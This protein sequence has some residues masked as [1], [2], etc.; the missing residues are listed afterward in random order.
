MNI[1]TQRIELNGR[2]SCDG[3]YSHISDKQHEVMDINLT[4]NKT[5]T[6]STKLRKSYY[7]NCDWKRIPQLGAVF[8][9]HNSE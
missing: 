8:F 1:G 6:V 9:F 7:V 3:Y 5:K 4:H 2:E